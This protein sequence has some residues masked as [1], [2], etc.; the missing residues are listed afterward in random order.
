MDKKSREEISSFYSTRLSKYGATIDALDNRSVE[1]QEVRFIQATQVEPISPYSSILDVGCGLGFFCDFLRQIGWK[2]EYS[3]FDI[4]EDILGAAQRR[5]PDDKFTF[6]DILETQCL[7]KYDYVFCLA[8]MHQKPPFM[9]GF[10]YLK[11]MVQAM[12]SICNQAVIFDV[13][14]NNG[15][16][17]DEKKIYLDPAELLNFCSTL[18]E[19]YTIRKDAR[20][21]EIMTY[22]Y[23]P[24]AKENN[25]IYSSWKKKIFTI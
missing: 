23:K 4:C 24:T 10:T 12:F 5:L 8:T 7:K 19:R 3:G 15:D 21:Y 1:H 13:F 25:N 11:A 22:L 9:D 18:T 20:P 2:G 17:T 6:F 16:Y 14:S